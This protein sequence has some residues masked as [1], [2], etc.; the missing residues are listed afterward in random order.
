M[1]LLFTCNRVR[2]SCGEVHI[3]HVGCCQLINVK[4]NF[5]YILCTKSHD[6]IYNNIHSFIIIIIG[7]AN[8]LNSDQD[9]QNIGLDLDSIIVYSEKIFKRGP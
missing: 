2:F 4:D 1:P 8:S 6:T 9:R 7:F 3:I 5:P